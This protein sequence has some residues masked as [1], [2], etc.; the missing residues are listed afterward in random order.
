M[1]A[2][3]GLGNTPLKL[4]PI[5]VCLIQFLAGAVGLAYCFA[6]MKSQHFP[7]F[8]MVIEGIDGAGKT[9]QADRIQSA[10]Q[11]LGFTVVRTKEPTAGRWGKLLRDSALTGRLSMEEEVETFIK[12][13]REHV[14]NLI[15]P[16]LRAGHVEK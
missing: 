9:T 11:G 3:Q 15:L 2:R 12:D 6:L 13:R 7:G 4:R 10:L 16:E 1:A 14:E 5:A 8:L